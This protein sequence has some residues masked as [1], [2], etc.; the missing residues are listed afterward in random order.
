MFVPS[1]EE[2]CGLLRVP[3]HD[4]VDPCRMIDRGSSPQHLNSSTTTPHTKVPS[5]SQP[6]LRQVSPATEHVHPCSELPKLPCIQTPPTYARQLPPPIYAFLTQH[7]HQQATHYGASQPSCRRPNNILR[8][9]NILPPKHD[10]SRPPP[11]RTRPHGLPHNRRF[12]PARRR[13]DTRLETQ[14]TK[15]HKRGKQRRGPVGGTATVDEEEAREAVFHRL[16]SLG[17]RVGL[18]VV[19]R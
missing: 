13:M 15:R 1:Y 19:E 3:S 17:Y 5:H 4:M 14:A 6:H 18:G 10:M 11:C 9:P 16:E 7:H 12:S 8:R 2:A